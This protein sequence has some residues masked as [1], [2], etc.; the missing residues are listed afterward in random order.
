MNKYF[1]PKQAL[2]II[3]EI[4]PERT[5]LGLSHLT[6]YRKQGLIG[7]DERRVQKRQH[8]DSFSFK[9][10][11]LLAWMLELKEAGIATDNDAL[12]IR[13]AIG[14]LNFE[15]LTIPVENVYLSGRVGSLKWS[16]PIGQTYVKVFKAA[17]KLSVSF[18]NGKR[19]QQEK[20]EILPAGL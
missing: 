15:T 9:D 13:K 6:Y 17:K 3:R 8:G 16:Y 10:V 5:Q 11:V 18:N 7:S 4:F 14:T 12:G 1:S 19:W 2:L 20:T